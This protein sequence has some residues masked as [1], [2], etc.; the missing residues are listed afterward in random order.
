MSYTD[1]FGGETIF[2]SQLSYV[3]ITTAVDV[4]L[5]WPREQ[6]IEGTNVVADF[7]DINTTAGGLNIDMPDARNTSTGN[8]A[9]FNNVGANTFT[10]RDNTGGTIQSVQSGEQWV[11]VLTDN[12]TQAG[13]WSTFLLGGNAATPASASVLAGAGLRANGAQLDQIIDSDIEPAT[14]I[15]VVDGDRAKC[16]IYTAG[17]GTANLPNPAGVGN[18]WFFMLRNSGSG[19]LNVLPP[20]GT[21]DGSSSINLNPSDSAFIFTDGTDYYTIGL[22]AG[23]TIG[24][25]FVSLPIPGSG[26]FVLS[27]ANLDRIAYRFTGALTGNR[28]VV[29]PTTI[30][31]YWCDNQTTGAFTL[32]IGTAAQAVPP[33]LD[34]AKTAI[35]Y[36]D[37]VDV[38][39]AVNAVSVMF[40]ILISQ[41]GT[42]ATNAADART[43][44]DVPPNTRL[45]DTGVGISGGGDLST[46]RTHDLDYT[47]IP[48]ATPAA[49]DF[50]TF[51]DI[52]DSDNIKKTTIS[53]INQQLFDTSGNVR[54]S[55]ET[56]GVAQLRSDGNT[57]GEVR[58]L[59]GT[60][61]DGTERWRIGQPT[62]SPDL[63][64]ENLLIGGDI[65]LISGPSS[66]ITLNPAG[67]LRLLA[68]VLPGIVDIFADGATDTEQHLIQLKDSGGNIKGT[69]G[70]TSTEAKMHIENLINGQD[71]ELRGENFGGSPRTYFFADPD[72]ETTYLYG[73]NLPG[74]GAQ[75][76]TA[77]GATTGG[78]VIDSV[79]NP[80]PVGFNVIPGRTITTNQTM[81][82]DF[83]G[84]MW[85]KT[86]GGAIIITL[87][88]DSN[89]PAGAT[90][91][92][93]NID[94]EAISINAGGGVTLRWFD[95]ST[96]GGAIGNRTLASG[97]VVTIR[98]SNDTNFQ[99]WG[100]GIS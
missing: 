43:N 25:D 8:K 4:T 78:V 39:D 52:D 70:W 56:L 63:I 22:S 24:F 71:F 27:G 90:V 74:I 67:I 77:A 21:I 13:T 10:V 12:S 44:L 32:S 93:C 66:G 34:P 9:T 23:S 87:P 19:A 68:S 3:S 36:C 65:D 14:P 88:N 59:Q 37:G 2:P 84:R 38:I 98:K 51:Q 82:D 96:S 91:M 49:G 15:T 42:S 60:H 40:P 35:L 85:E 41:G 69:W 55:A 20:A 72:A 83:I 89:I 45:V 46:D 47:A 99:V 26:D 80:F 18:N 33:T 1:V 50:F 53:G 31:Q 92:V 95:G 76:R 57:D 29:V 28:K 11:L 62:I 97:G 100:N 73:G 79:A 61:Q 5:Q 6:Q 7:L 75:D 81:D 17:A 30:Q 48:T 16:L 64:I 94:T 54:I 86:S 58:V